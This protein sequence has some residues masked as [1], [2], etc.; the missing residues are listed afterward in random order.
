[1]RW[2]GDLHI[3]CTLPKKVVYTTLELDQMKLPR[4]LFERIVPCTSLNAAA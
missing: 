4:L 1:M 2:Q 3:R